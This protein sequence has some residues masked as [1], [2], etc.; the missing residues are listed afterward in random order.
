MKHPIYAPF[1]QFSYFSYFYPTPSYTQSFLL[2][3]FKFPETTSQTLFNLT[4]P[5]PLPLMHLTPLWL[6]CNQDVRFWANLAYP[7]LSFPVPPPSPSPFPPSYYFLD[8]GPDKKLRT[9]DLVKIC[10]RRD[11][12][13]WV[14]G[15]CVNVKGGWGW[16]EVGRH[17]CGCGEYIESCG[18]WKA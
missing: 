17:M 1:S 10:G 15:C 8:P 14:G 3:C 11:N 18:L 2:K 5:P 16:E 13:W 4:P 9:C 12:S 7:S 6:S